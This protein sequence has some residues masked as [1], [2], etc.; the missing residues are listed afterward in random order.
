MKA[1]QIIN[2]L[3]KN[4]KKIII[5]CLIF[6][7]LS[8]KVSENFTTTQALDAVKSTEKKVNDVYYSIDANWVKSKKSIYSQNGLKAE[9]QIISGK[10][11]IIAASGNVNAAGN[12]NA[13][14]NINTKKEFCI[15]GTCINENVLKKLNTGEHDLH[16]PKKKGCYLWSKQPCE[17][18]RGRGNEM[19]R[20]WFYDGSGGGSEGK[21]KARIK[22]YQK[23]HCKNNTMY[24]QFNK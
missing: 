21:C 9:G 8:K 14:G 5:I 20:N 15:G 18:N 17:K 19:H 3:K 4:F 10:G 2:F 16:R 11:D 23:S 12:V 1:K 22:D 7:I 13:E 24:F 6:L